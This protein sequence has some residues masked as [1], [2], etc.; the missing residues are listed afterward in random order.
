MTMRNCTDR[1]GDEWEVFEVF[2]AHSGR[3]LNHLPPAFRSGWLCFQSESERRRLAP[4]PPGWDRWEEGK[5]LAALEQT[6]GVPRRTP[7]PLGAVGSPPT[8]QRPQNARR[9]T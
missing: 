9:K 7:R 8:F 2:P 5:L 6:L 1:F 3:D 4:I